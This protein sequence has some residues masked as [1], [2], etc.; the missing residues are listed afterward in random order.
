MR[1]CRKEGL[2][3]RDSYRR[4]LAIESGNSL[5]NCNRGRLLNLLQKEKELREKKITDENEKKIIGISTTVID[6]VQN[7]SLDCFSQDVKYNNTTD[8]KTKEMLKK[9]KQVKL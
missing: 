1:I 2:N 9:I 5:L 3:K 4:Y 7:Q 8:Y 6:D